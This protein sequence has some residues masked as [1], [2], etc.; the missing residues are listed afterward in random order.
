[1]S[2][3]PQKGLIDV[4]PGLVEMLSGNDL[5]RAVQGIIR[6]FM[7]PDAYVFHSRPSAQQAVGLKLSNS[8]ITPDTTCLLVSF[9]LHVLFIQ[10]SGSKLT[11]LGAILELIIDMLDARVSV[12]EHVTGKDFDTDVVVGSPVQGLGTYF[13]EQSLNAGLLNAIELRMKQ[14]PAFTPF[15]EYLKY[16]FPDISTGLDE[17]CLHVPATA[18]AHCWSHPA[19]TYNKFKFPRYHI[20]VLKPLLETLKNRASQPDFKRTLTSTLEKHCGTIGNLSIQQ[21]IGIVAG[22]VGYKDTLRTGS[23]SLAAAWNALDFTGAL[24]WIATPLKYFP[25]GARERAAAIANS[26]ASATSTLT[27]TVK[28]A[29]SG[30]KSRLGL[31]GRRTRRRAP[32]RRKRQRIGTKYFRRFQKH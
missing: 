24:S 13:E 6:A 32:T 10:D 15:Y 3:P 8:Q 22:A 7:P 19:D 1:M 20:L 14:H 31:G 11:L 18:P 16:E 5:D 9:V 29:L 17:A 4:L 25:L 28:G 12:I 23:L 2:A 30:L 26:A 27:G 21:I